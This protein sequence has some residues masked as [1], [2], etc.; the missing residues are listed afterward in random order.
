MGRHGQGCSGGL[1]RA[2]LRGKGDSSKFT[3]HA[4][5]RYSEEVSVQRDE[6]SAGFS[7]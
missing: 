1:S 3:P 7:S 6:K 5:D 4:E 2:G